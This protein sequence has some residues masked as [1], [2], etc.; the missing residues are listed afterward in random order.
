M[1][2]TIIAFLTKIPNKP[3][4]E[5][6]KKLT[7]YYDVYIFIDDNNYEEHKKDNSKIK[8]IQI[9]NNICI[10]NGFQYTLE[11]FLANAQRKINTGKRISSYDKFFYYFMMLNENYDYVWVI[12]DDVFIPDYKNIIDLNDKCY[13]YDLVCA[14][15]TKGTLKDALNNEWFWPYAITIFG[16]PSYCSMVC[17]CRLSKKL[18]NK[19]KEK[20]LELKFIPFLEF[21]YN[22]VANMHNLKILCPE[23]LS[24]IV[25]RT[26]W[27]INDFKKKRK[28]LFHPL[29]DFEKHE[30]YRNLL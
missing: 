30:Y 29:K 24:T 27:N 14:K 11:I 4:I 22:S 26:D 1:N 17:A 23:E 2:K 10:S 19:M 20:I 28:N 3:L 8:Y 18:M 15:N 6:A 5:I 12:E 16:D 21:F 25:Y 13:D 7:D 9:D